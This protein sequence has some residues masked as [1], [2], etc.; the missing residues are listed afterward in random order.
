[1]TIATR[2]FT[3]GA[4]RSFCCVL[5]IL[6]FAP[7]G[8]ALSLD[9]VRA[10][11]AAKR[12]NLKATLPL[13]SS[14]WAGACTTAES[15]FRWRSCSFTA[16]STKLRFEEWWSGDAIWYV[17]TLTDYYNSFITGLLARHYW[18]SSVATYGTIFIEIT[19]P[20]LIWQ[21]R[22]RPYLLAAAI[23]LHVIFILC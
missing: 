14:P 21:R 5:F 3:Y 8:R 9:R 23:F 10:V 6:C 18:L 15:N 4:D 13:Y 19:F 20:F 7:V 2:R 1:M 12:K 16:P 17:F 22:T 11:R